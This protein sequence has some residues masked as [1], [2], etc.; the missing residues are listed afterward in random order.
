MSL[1]ELDHIT[2]PW[3]TKSFPKCNNVCWRDSQRRF[4][5]RKK[6]GGKLQY[7]YFS[8]TDYKTPLDAYRAACCCAKQLDEE[9]SESIRKFIERS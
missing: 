9:A 7:R 5:V 4:Q 1:S 3:D 2:N 8:L 6:V